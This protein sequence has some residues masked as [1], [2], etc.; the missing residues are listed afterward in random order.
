MSRIYEKIVST[1]GIERE[2]EKDISRFPFCSKVIESLA[3]C[4]MKRI[5]QVYGPSKKTCK[6]LGVEL[7][8]CLATS[9]CPSEFEEFKS[10][11]KK[12]ENCETKNILFL[13]CL[14]LKT[15][16]LNI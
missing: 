7:E 4:H 13:N 6:Q 10:C 3:D 2:K 11:Q 14:A 12:G 16:G 1:S 5:T 15:G 8:I 9:L